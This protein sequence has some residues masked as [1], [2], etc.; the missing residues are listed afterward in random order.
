MLC[1]GVALRCCCTAPIL[2]GSD[3]LLPLL[4]LLRQCSMPCRCNSPLLPL[5]GCCSAYAPTVLQRVHADAQHDA[6][7]PS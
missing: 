7:Y 4:L 6:R 1:Q 3:V 2:V 5:F